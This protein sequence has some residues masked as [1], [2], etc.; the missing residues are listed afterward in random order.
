M[1]CGR[2]YR[3]KGIAEAGLPPVGDLC[4]LLKQRWY[5]TPYDVYQHLAVVVVSSDPG[6]GGAEML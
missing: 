4:V 2:I 1:L 5:V 6:P 3:E